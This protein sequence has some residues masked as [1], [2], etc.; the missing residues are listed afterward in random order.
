MFASQLLNILFNALLMFDDVDLMNELLLFH[1]QVTKR[2][3]YS[4][5]WIIYKLG[6]S[7]FDTVQY[8]K[9]FSNF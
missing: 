9:T 5:V 6:H 7:Q 4:E 8:Y 1:I 3:K 2:T